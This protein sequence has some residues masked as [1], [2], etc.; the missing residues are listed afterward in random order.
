[1]KNTQNIMAKFCH[2]IFLLLC[3]NLSSCGY[4]G[5]L[6]LPQPDE[7]YSRYGPIQTGTDLKSLPP[8]EGQP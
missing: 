5:E 2:F 4:K 1:L 6:H 8:K 7:D 3:L